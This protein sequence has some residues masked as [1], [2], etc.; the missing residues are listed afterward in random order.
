M[1]AYSY[2]PHRLVRGIYLLA[3]VA[4]INP[5]RLVPCAHGGQYRS[6]DDML[7]LQGWGRLRNLMQLAYDS[8]DATRRCLC[9]PATVSNR[10]HPS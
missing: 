2:F 3:L 10:R 5:V 1:V 7:S 9:R 8:D 6:T 4:P